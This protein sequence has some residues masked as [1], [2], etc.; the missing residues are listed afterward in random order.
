MDESHQH[1]GSN[2]MR[3]HTDGNRETITRAAFAAGVDLVKCEEHGSRTHARA[4][5]VSLRGSSRRR[6]N[7]WDGSDCYAATWDQWGIFLAHIFDAD[8]DARCGSVKH[9]TYRDGDD[10]HAKTFRRFLSTF[11]IVFPET[12][13]PIVV[14]PVTPN[15]MH[16]DHTFRFSGT[17]YV[18]QCTKCTAR[19]TWK[20]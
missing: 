9:P 1:D 7:F 10:F 18:Q 8:T 20:V 2:T 19:F 13:R 12:D 17:P 11:L 14:E 4:F 3:I 6:P 5:E 15:D 16:G